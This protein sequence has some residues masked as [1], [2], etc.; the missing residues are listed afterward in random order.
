MKLHT[1]PHLQRANTPDAER[2]HVLSHELRTPLAVISGYA[3]VLKDEVQESK[4][5]LVAPILENVARLDHV[6]STLLEWESTS[7]TQPANNSNC[8]LCQITRNVVA[9]FTTL[10]ESKGLSIKMVSKEQ[11]I[12][13]YSSSDIIESAIGQLL[14]NAIKFSDSG[15]IRVS[16]QS[17]S[18]QIS[19]SIED[20][21]PGINSEGPDLFEPFT[22]GSTG[23]SRKYDGLGLGLSL[24]QTHLARISGTIH[25]LNGEISGAKA[26]IS[27]PR[28]SA[29]SETGGSHSIAA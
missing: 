21:G 17:T 7:A 25:L 6:I 13:A 28:F 3:Q 11:K 9:K 8:D 24:A 19:I 5:D 2:I 20:E 22:Q 15:D 4:I 16:I 12:A 23:L 1:I 29:M 18:T 27:F 26:L 14:H 10:A